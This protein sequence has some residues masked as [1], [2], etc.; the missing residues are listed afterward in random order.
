[1]SQT[2]NYYLNLVANDSLDIN[3]KQMKKILITTLFTF[4]LYLGLSSFNS[5]DNGYN[6]GDKIDGFKLKNIDNKMVSLS[7]YNDAKGYIIIFTCN[8]CPYSVL[9]EDRIIELHK[10]YEPK[11][12]P[13]IAINSNSEKVQPEDS[14]EKMIERAND[15]K[16]PFVY[17][18]DKDQSVAKKFGAARTPHVFVV[19]KKDMKVKYIGAIDDN[20]KHAN[21]ARKH[22]VK[23]AVDNLLEGKKV[24]KEKTKAIGCT[25]KWAK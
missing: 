25:I 21:K 17:L 7:D 23:D 3:F 13:V 22:Y 10:E 8:H 6:V 20:A 9:Y 15:K 18:H 1:M 5:Y 12:Y 11:G 16:F 24:I 4:A 19:Q 2:Q 14:F